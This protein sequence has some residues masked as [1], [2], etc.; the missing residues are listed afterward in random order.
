V[1][2][3]ARYGINLDA[4][5]GIISQF[6]I[7]HNHLSPSTGNAVYITFPSGSD[8][9]FDG[10]LEDNLLF[11]GINLTRGGDN[12]RLTRNQ[13]LGVGPGIYASLV[14]GAVGPEIYFNTITS[15]SGGIVIA[16]G[17]TPKIENNS[18]EPAAGCATEANGASIDILG[19][20]G[21]PVLSPQVFNNSCSIQAG[22]NTSCIRF[23]YVT[24][25][26]IISNTCYTNAGS[27]EFCIAL[28]A[29][30]TGTIYGLNDLY[31]S[32]TLLSSS[33][34]DASA[35]ASLNVAQTWGALQTFPSIQF[36]SGG[37]VGPRGQYL[38]FYY[39]SGT[40]LSYYDGVSVVPGIAAV[41]GAGAVLPQPGEALVFKSANGTCYPVTMSNI[42]VLTAGTSI[43][44]PI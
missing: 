23:D 36:P 4:T 42:G 6:V 13:L 34:T 44:C 41:S 32:G 2:A 3:P 1:G 39:Y 29:H 19:S 10:V 28:T 37:A 9:V 18:I 26:K 11:G 25:G 33:E 14:S 22:L 17:A 31:G 43:T 24:T 20:S 21:N 27:S 8:G 5:S 15:C 40:T 38:D 12:I 7:R 30:P 16:Q 35:L